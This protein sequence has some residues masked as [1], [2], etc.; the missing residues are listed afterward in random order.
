M[1]PRD[2]PDF[3]SLGVGDCRGKGCVGAHFLGFLHVLWPL[4]AVRAQSTL[5]V[6]PRGCVSWGAV[7]SEGASHLEPGYAHQ[8]SVRLTSVLGG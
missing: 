3:M 4:G 5:A 7:L 2:S 6:G 8:M 1:G